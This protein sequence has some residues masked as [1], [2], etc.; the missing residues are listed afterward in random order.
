[1]TFKEARQEARQIAIKTGYWG[2]VFKDKDGEWY[3]SNCKNFNS[4]ESFYVDKSG[5]VCNIQNYEKV[6]KKLEK[7]GIVGVLPFSPIISSNEK[8]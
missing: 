2:Y 4:D 8:K 3:T 7:Q 5:K 1:M 6:I